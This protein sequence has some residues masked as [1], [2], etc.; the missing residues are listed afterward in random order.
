MKKLCYSFKTILLNCYVSCKVGWIEL[1]T[2]RIFRQISSINKSLG[3]AS[4][5][6]KNLGFL[7]FLF[8]CIFEKF[9]HATNLKLGLKKG[10]W[11]GIFVKISTIITEGFLAEIHM[12]AIQKDLNMERLQIILE[13]ILVKRRIWWLVFFSL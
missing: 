11:C 12:Y 9:A 2:Y 13:S 7:W 6:K 4:I 3:A 1:R 5:L 10:I 8:L